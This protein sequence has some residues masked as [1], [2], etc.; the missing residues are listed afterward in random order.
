MECLWYFFIHAQCPFFGTELV[1]KMLVRL[2]SLDFLHIHFITVQAYV[3]CT[4]TYCNVNAHGILFLR[5]L[6]ATY[7][8]ERQK[9]VNK[10]AQHFESEIMNFI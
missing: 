10:K 8:T 4:S 7:L 9:N 5:Q 3:V 1:I 6:H 2:I